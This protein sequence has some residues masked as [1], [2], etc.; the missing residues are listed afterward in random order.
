V[1]ENRIRA[2]QAG[3]HL[4]ISQIC[5]LICE[6]GGLTWMVGGN[7]DAIAKWRQQV[8]EAAKLCSPYN[9]RQKRHWLEFFPD[10]NG[11]VFVTRRV[12]N[13]RTL[14]TRYIEAKNFAEENGTIEA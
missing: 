1:E 2:E 12:I 13:H 7:T 11:R 3:K 8:P 14:R 6:R 4:S 9:V 5:K 10:E